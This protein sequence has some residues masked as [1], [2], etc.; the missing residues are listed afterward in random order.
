MVRMILSDIARVRLVITLA[1]ATTVALAACGSDDGAD[2]TADSADDAV[3]ATTSIWADITS[4]VGCG[5]PIDTLIPI[6][7]DPHTFEPSLRD[8]ELIE[9]STTVISNGLGLEDNLSDLL[10]TASDGGVNVIEMANHVDVITDD[11]GDDADDAD[12]DDADHDD[13]EEH[14]HDHGGE[15]DPHVWQDPLRVAGTLDTIGTALAA[16][17]IDVCIDEYRDELLA[18]D[19][20][21]EAS[22]AD[23]PAP[24]RVLVTSHDSLAYF[25]DR[26]GFEIVGTVIPSTSTLA[27]TN[28]ADLADLAEVIDDD[29]VP[30]IFTEELESTADADALA[31]RLDVAVVPL[32]TDSLTDDPAT[33]TYVEMMR[34]NAAAIASALAP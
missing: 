29:D 34:Y 33:D 10:E 27:E 8:R 19:A 28:A 23:V 2:S 21:I 17:D 9:H 1:V 20:D 4:S 7:A 3:I 16:H 24:S 11:D 5:T 22:L 13:A 31:A 25:A 30:A 18:L 14:Q 32:V 6:G 15:G 26:Y 12:H